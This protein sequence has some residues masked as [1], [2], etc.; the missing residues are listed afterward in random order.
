MQEF[1]YHTHTTFSDGHNTAR[2]MIEQAERLGLKEIGIS[3]HLIVHK[4][5]SKVGNYTYLQK[6][7]L[8]N[9]QDAYEQCSK[10]IEHLRVLQKEYNIKIRIGFETDFF[11]YNGWKEDFHNLINKLDYD[12]L[13]NGNHFLMDETGKNIEDIAY[14]TQ[15]KNSVLNAPFDSY[16][17][18]YFQTME[19]AIRSGKFSFLAHMDY[20]KKLSAYNEKNF[21]KDIQNVIKALQETNT[22]CEINT[23][24]LRRVGDLYPSRNII[25][26]MVCHDVALLISDDA[27]KINDL[28]FQF[29]ETDKMLELLKAKRFYLK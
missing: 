8:T 20:I 11:I 14:L 18:R 2:E 26:N 29:D 17:K 28:R 3:D 25:E 16:I 4:N 9:F 12:Y 19:K 10:Y 6:M 21:S 23:K 5:I 15:G 1:T 22:A 24:G 27:H 13:I 7:T